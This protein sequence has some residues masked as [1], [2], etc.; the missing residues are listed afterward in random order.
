[1]NED[2]Y[3]RK[4]FKIKMTNRALYIMLYVY[5][6]LSLF[7]YIKF[8]FTWPFIICMSLLVIFLF[9]FTFHGLKHA[10]ELSNPNYIPDKPPINKVRAEVLSILNSPE[11][12]RELTADKLMKL[13]NQNSIGDIRTYE[14][15]L[16]LYFK[17]NGMKSDA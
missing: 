17:H 9:L 14:S 10:A 6:I 4:L 2:D 16:R 15:E 7:F 13:F 11:S 3:K 1:M 12:N 5:I 8:D